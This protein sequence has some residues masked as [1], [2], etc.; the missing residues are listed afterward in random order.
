MKK[1]VFAILVAVVATN[2]F[3]AETFKLKDRETGLIFGPFEFKNG[4]EVKIKGKT[5][6]VTSAKVPPTEVHEK[7]EKI[8]IPEIS[9]TEAT[10]HQVV[11]YLRN[12]SEQLDPEGVGVN[13]LVIM[14]PDAPVYTE[15]A[16]PPEDD[17]WPAGQ[18][19]D[20]WDTERAQTE[21]L[22]SRRRHTIT[23]QLKRVSLG[24]ALRLIATVA[25]QDM[26]IEDNAVILRPKEK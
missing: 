2:A 24:Q 18:D 16:T 6:V 14:P 9:F 20:A 1:T 21:V 26:Y 17:E 19:G 11:Y 12:K 8:I 4:A 25:H 7:L 5:F 22:A 13:I 3:G 10:L 23:M 15:L